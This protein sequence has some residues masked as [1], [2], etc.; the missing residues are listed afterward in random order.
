MGSQV[1]TFNIGCDWELFGVC[2]TISWNWGKPEETDMGSK[3]V[4]PAA[5]HICIFSTCVENL[6]DS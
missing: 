4:F 2:D 5:S 6:P 3:R 1:T